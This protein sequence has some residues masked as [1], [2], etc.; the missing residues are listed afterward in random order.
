MNMKSSI[1]WV[2]GLTMIGETPS[3]HGVVMDGPEDFGGQNLGARPMEMILLG[4]GGCTLV[5][6]LVML[7]K[8]RQEVTDID[9]QVEAERGDTVPKVFTRIHVHFVVTGK[10][11]EERH[12]ERAVRLSSEKYCSV[13]R[14]LDQTVELS[15]GFEIREG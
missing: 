8:A 9:V 12:V 10:D 7:K 5:D 4:L 2:D 1:K 11:L 15:H 3:G 14:M 6:I 13:S